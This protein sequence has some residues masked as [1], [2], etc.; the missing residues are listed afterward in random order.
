MERNRVN[1][2]LFSSERREHF[3][4]KLR[5]E[6]LD[7]A[8]EARNGER[9]RMEQYR[10]L[11][12][13]EGV[14]SNLLEDYDK[15]REEANHSIDAAL[16]KVEADETISRTEKK[17]RAYQIKQ[18]AATRST[19]TKLVG[20]PNR[21]VAA[22]EARAEERRETAQRERDERYQERAG[23]RQFRRERNQNFAQRTSRGQPVMASRVA[24]L[25]QRIQ[26]R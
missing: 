15:K 17:R 6:A 24:D 4:K 22:A 7:Q 14:K 13:Q 18:K 12:A 16:A 23:K 3:N 5:R 2:R 19:T 8:R 9:Q 20:G 26:R 21:A 25:L 10:R 1:S 11:C